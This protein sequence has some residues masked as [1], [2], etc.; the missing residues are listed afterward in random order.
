VRGE[1]EVRQ[2]Q[3]EV[4]DS[5]VVEATPWLPAEAA[6]DEVST[7]AARSDCDGGERLV[8]RRGRRRLGRPAEAKGGTWTEASVD[9]GRTYSRRRLAA[10]R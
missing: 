7:W 1:E 8:G 5:R 6:R 9:H 10:L 4:G 2:A 3:I